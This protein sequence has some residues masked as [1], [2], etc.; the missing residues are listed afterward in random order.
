MM[1]EKYHRASIFSEETVWTT[2]VV[3]AEA[4]KLNELVINTKKEI[5]YSSLQRKMTLE[6]EKWIHH[7]KNNRFITFVGAT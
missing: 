4:S 2:S 6:K 7:E 5:N 1:V 3:L